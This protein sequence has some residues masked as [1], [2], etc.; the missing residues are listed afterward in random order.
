MK[1]KSIKIENYRGIRTAQNIQLSNFTS[2]VGRNDSGK[3]II[4]NAVATFL[5]IKDY[6][7]TFHDFNDFGN[8]IIIECSFGKENILEILEAKI[9]T[10]IKKENGLDEFLIDI[11]PNNL[12]TIRKT[13]NAPKKAFDTEQILISDYDS[14]DFYFL[15]GK[16]DDELN[17]ILEKYEIEI[18]V[19]GKGRNSKIEKIKYIKEYCQGNEIPTINRFIDDE[20][21]VTSLLPDV[22][23]FVSDYGLEAD[24][25]FKS[26]SVSE[27]QLYLD[28]ESKEEKKLDLVKK[29]I[30]SEMQKEASSVKSYMKTYVSSL[31]SVEIKPTISWKDAIKSVDVSFQ[32]D[33]DDKLIPMSHK[34]TGY[35]RLFMVARF[36]YLAEKKKGSNIIYLIEEPETFLHPSAQEDLINAFR[37]LSEENQI[38]ISTHSPIFVGATDI[39]SV[40]LCKKEEQ[41]TYVT[42][43]EENKIDFINEI[44]KEL[45]VKPSFNLRDDFEKILFVEGKDDLEFYKKVTSELLEK[46]LEEKALILPVGG[47]SVDSFVNISYFKNNGRDLFLILDSDRG[48]SVKDPKKP[49]IQIKSAENFNDHFGKSYLLKKSNIESYFHPRALER[50]YRHIANGSMHF[51]EDDEYLNDFFRDNG[52][53]KKHNTAIF[54]EMSK[55]EWSEVIEDDLIDFLNGIIN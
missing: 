46:N 54:N 32:F 35:R 41:S 30:E 40:V 27:I 43:T 28:E 2:I 34:G 11:L 42:T 18:P 48:L 44:I 50:N 52:I 47:S 14:P 8:P 20:Y 3:S 49:L 51:F 55:E 6:P 15:Y 19:E 33:G 10:K 5:N 36:R 7:V 39:N 9:K 37:D 23:L 13:I 24:T 45:G 12:L 26:N 21:K 38:I 22:E 1:I 4:L 29:E 25:K 16:S 17:Q 53:N 31:K